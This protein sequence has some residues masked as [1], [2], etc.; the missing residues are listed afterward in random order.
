MLPE[1]GLGQD[2]RTLALESKLLESALQYSATTGLPPLVAWLKG[3]QAAEHGA[4]NVDVRGVGM[5]RGEE[6]VCQGWKKV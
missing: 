2:G 3:L 4:K 5:M 6:R 1:D